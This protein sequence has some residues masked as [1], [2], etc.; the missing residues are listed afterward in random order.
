[1]KI[2]I[3]PGHGGKDPGAVGRCGG[4]ELCEHDIALQ[5]SL[6]LEQALLL[7]NYSTYMTRRIDRTL[8]LPARSQFANRFHVDLF[9]SIHCNAAY[10]ESAEGI[11]T[12]IH[13]S[14]SVGKKHA[15]PIQK[16]LI[17][18]FPNHK[19]RGIKEAN[20]HVLRETAMPAVLV[21][22]EFITQPEQ[23]AFLLAD[24]NQR[25]I[26]WAIKEGIVSSQQL[27]V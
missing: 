21:E 10:T 25:R 20:F 5:I 16:A 4:Q 26:A 13:P 8:S 23:A 1:M 9:V 14:S 15:D 18:E 6:Y 17:A 27:L 2:C 24:E 19:N 7:D 11:E 12:W 3:D 22:T